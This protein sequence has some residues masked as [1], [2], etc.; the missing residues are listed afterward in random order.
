MIR[1]REEKTGGKPA[2]ACSGR[3]NGVSREEERVGER[4]KQLESGS[5]KWEKERSERGER[6]GKVQEEGKAEAG[7]VT[8]AAVTC[9]ACQAPPM[10]RPALHACICNPKQ[11]VLL[12]CFSLFANK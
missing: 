3:R 2:V 11:H 9:T 12:S 8:A 7:A 5:L 6:G 4:G 10:L 1:E